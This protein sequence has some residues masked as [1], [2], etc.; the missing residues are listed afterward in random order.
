M[1]KNLSLRL[2]FFTLVIGL[3]LGFLIFIVLMLLGE[4]KSLKITQETLTQ[5]VR[6]EIE[7]KIKLSTDSMAHSLGE[8]V[9]GLSEEEQIRAIAKAIDTFYYENDKSGYYFVC[10]A[11][12][13]VAHPNRKDTVGVSFHETKDINGVYYINELYDSA[14]NPTSG[15]KFV[16]YTFTK[17]L[18]DGTFTDHMKVGYA[19]MIPNTNDIWIA[20]GVYIDTLENHTQIVSSDILSRIQSSLYNT[21]SISVF[22]LVVIFCPLLWIFYS[23]LKKGL[24]ILQHN[25]FSFFK[26]VNREVAQVNFIPLHSKDEIGLM[27]QAV[28]ENVQT[29]VKALEQDSALVNDVLHIVAEA[30]VGKF[31]SLIINTS[32][33]PQINE[34]REAINE[35]S[36]TLFNLVGDDLGKEE[37]VLQAYSNNDFTPRIHDARGIGIALNDLGNAM[38]KMLTVSLEH[39]H[40][41]EAKSQELEQAVKELT[42]S[43]NIQSSSL[44]QTAT[45]IEEITSSMQSMSGRTNEVIKQ[46][47]NIKNIIEVIRDIAEQTNL[48]ALNAAIEAARAGEHGKGFAVVADEVRKLAERTQKSLGEVE[49]NTNILVQG[50]NDMAESITEQAQGI[51]QIN[52]SIAQLEDITQKNVA[53]ANHS[54]N[55]SNALE[56]VATKILDD[57]SSKK[58]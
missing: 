39:A 50:I 46:S 11:Y 16:H 35:M 4:Q 29:R 56:S 20:T 12:T 31:G 17:P 23:T 53:I 52:E 25:I 44:Q 6:R 14:K 54:Q 28:N 55:T 38:A 37:K 33:N 24:G 49:A 18:A 48:L 58:F 21:I 15:G 5:E 8:F 57:V 42:Q 41:L 36:V 47:E 22:A 43:A 45:A 3:F 7:Q 51:T 13:M 10:K 1:Y 19:A 9:R 40:E 30:K 27:V 26:Y 2:K 32:L 34:L